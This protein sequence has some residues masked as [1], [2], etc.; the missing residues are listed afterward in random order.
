ME[1][2]LER[3]PQFCILRYDVPCVGVAVEPGEIAAGNLQAYPV[4]CLEHIAGGPEVD[5]VAIGPA[6]L[7]QCV[8]GCHGIRSGARASVLCPRQ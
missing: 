8:Q 2:G 1:H 7:Q 4:A 5:L 6:Q 3:G